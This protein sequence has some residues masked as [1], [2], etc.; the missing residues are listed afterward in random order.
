MN[1]DKLHQA[2]AEFLQRYPGGFAD[3]GM[4]LIKRKHNVDKVV[5]FAAANLRLQDFN[6]PQH[7]ADSMLKI[8]SRSSM[9]SRFEKPRFRD[10]ISALNSHEKEALADAL[11]QRL[12]GRKKAGFEAL[13]GMLDH[14]GVAKWPLLTAVPFYAAPRRE[15][16]VKPTTAK[17][18]ITFL[19]VADLEY[20]PRP[21]WE[22]YRGYQ[23]LLRE[24][25]G[26]VSKSLA[27]N[28]AALSGFLMSSF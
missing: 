27:P 5:E 25:R 13:L 7:I 17:G 16:F 12:Y 28:Y 4:D 8:I 6:R 1:I 9:V 23:A 21:S 20:K 11:E 3:P 18:I 22:F 14:Y 15:V 24:V 2:E 19:Q 26:E 10:F